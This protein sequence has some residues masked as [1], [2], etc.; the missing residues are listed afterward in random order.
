MQNHLYSK[1]QQ[2]VQTLAHIL[3][4]VEN[5]FQKQLN[6][7]TKFRTLKFTCHY[8]LLDQQLP[9]KIGKTS[10]KEVA[11]S[12]QSL[13]STSN[14]TMLANCFEKRIAKNRNLSMQRKYFF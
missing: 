2:F 12:L 7:M 8:S 5:M 9:Q 10:D 3:T 6:C 13:H 1:T 14:F 4:P 11:T